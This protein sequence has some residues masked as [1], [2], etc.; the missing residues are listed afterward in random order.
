[1]AKKALLTVLLL[2]LILTSCTFEPEYLPPCIETPDEWKAPHPTP[3]EAPCVECWWEA[4][5]DDAL[6]F[7]EAQALVNN[8]TLYVALENVVQARALAG[9]R[10]ADLYPQIS[11]NP[12]FSDTGM[13]LQF[14]APTSLLPANVVVNDKVGFRVHQFQ[15]MLPMN[16]SYEID[17]WGKL[18][19]QYKSA[20][21]T[22][23][24]EQEAFYSTLLTLTTDLASSYY[25]LRSLDAQINLYN[26]TI[27]NLTKQYNIN[28][29][30]YDKGLTTYID[31]ANASLQLTNAQSSR[32]DLIRQRAL[33]EDAIAALIG[34]SPAEF[35]VPEAPLSGLPPLIPAGIPSAILVNRPDIA[36]AERNMASQHALIGVAYASFFP[37]LELTGA[38][39]FESPF[40]KEFLKWKSRYWM[41]GVNIGQSIFDGGRNCANLR[42]T[43]AGF[44]ET[45]GQY[46]QT[47]ITA[48][49]EVEDALYNL[50]MQSR[51]SA[52][53]AESVNSS[54]TA[55]QLAEKRYLQGVTNF[56]EVMIAQTQNLEAERSFII[57]QGVRFL[58][59][60][61]LIKALGGS[62]DC[63]N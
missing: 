6:N 32:E 11:L 24:A 39:G 45:E 23:Q 1:M 22:A 43:W 27:E 63:E 7:L 59:T 49:R 50:E 3:K 53:L 42:A 14:L 58:S 12:S 51:Q 35:C 5:E 15:Y 21:L 16:L 26:D 13:L 4:F 34:V 28:K 36:Q 19:G 20:C 31:V 18:R 2:F 37:S 17:L 55:Y 41:M 47:I 60:I 57:L 30:R 10:A 40:L 29:S 44:R 56:L 25:Q 62:W 38:L 54:K 33:Q 61:Q 9:V 46:R 48:F 52:Y 8:P